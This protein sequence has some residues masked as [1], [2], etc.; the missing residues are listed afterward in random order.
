[1]IWWLHTFPVQKWRHPAQYY[2]QRAGGQIWA[3]VKPPLIL[4]GDFF[5][6][7]GT[8]PSFLVPS[9]VQHCSYFAFG[10]APQ[11]LLA[12]CSDSWPLVE[13]KFRGG[14]EMGLV[15][16]PSCP[17]NCYVINVMAVNIANESELQSI[18]VDWVRFNTLFLKQNGHNK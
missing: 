2:K 9:S 6:P 3:R 18:S 10:D 17:Y 12:M 13:A 1:M 16:I 8:F 5:F 14:M 4:P 11:F 7:Q 15:L